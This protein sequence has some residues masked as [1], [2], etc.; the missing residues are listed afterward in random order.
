MRNH[1]PRHVKG[2]YVFFST[3]C[4]VKALAEMREDEGNRNKRDSYS[5]AKHKL[6]DLGKSRGDDSKT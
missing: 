4:T 2:L 6:R 3:K 1:A 5:R